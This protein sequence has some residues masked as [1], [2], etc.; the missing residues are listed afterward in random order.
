MTTNVHRLVEKGFANIKGNLKKSGPGQHTSV[1][2]IGPGE[3]MLELTPRGPYSIAT[4]LDSESTP[5]LATATCVW[6]GV[7]V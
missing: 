3:I 5:A 1:P 6:S 2:P 4:L 7:P